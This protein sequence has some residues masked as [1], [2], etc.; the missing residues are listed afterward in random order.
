M[1]GRWLLIVRLRGRPLNASIFVDTSRLSLLEFPASLHRF[2]PPFTIGRCWPSSVLPSTD[3]SA[4][5]FLA[6]TMSKVSF[7]KYLL[8]ATFPD[9]TATQTYKYFCEDRV[10]VRGTPLERWRRMWQ[11][12]R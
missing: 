9:L 1:D 8:P 7:Q 6:F 5:Y 2:F 11:R 3:I 10:D 4:R 12:L